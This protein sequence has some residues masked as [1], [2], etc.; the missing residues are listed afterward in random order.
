MNRLEHLSNS[1]KEVIVKIVDGYLNSYENMKHDSDSIFDTPGFWLNSLFSNKDCYISFFNKDGDLW[2]RYNAEDKDDNINRYFQF[3]NLKRVEIFTSINFL[4]WLHN[5]QLIFFSENKNSELPTYS[6]PKEKDLKKWES[7]GL[8]HYD[9]SLHSSSAFEFLNNYY[10]A[11]IIPSQSLIAFRQH[12]F[13]TVERIRHIRSQVASWCAILCAIFIALFSRTC[14][15]KI[16]MNQYDEIKNHMEK[17]E[18]I[19]QIMN[20]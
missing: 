16:D 4:Q 6:E 9:E 7:G 5:E 20:K 17:M 2:I 1:E 18:S 10:W 19:I 12:N 11:H 8:H 15:T 14:T 3:I 13:R